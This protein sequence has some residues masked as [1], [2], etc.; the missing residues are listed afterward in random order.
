MTT[1]MTGGIQHCTVQISVRYQYIKTAITHSTIESKIIR[2][3]ISYFETC[4]VD[5]D[6]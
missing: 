6:T 3:N 5:I 4:T 2:L 1:T